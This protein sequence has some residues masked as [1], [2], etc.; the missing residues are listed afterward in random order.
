M[1][2]G[3]QVLL[4]LLE[5]AVKALGPA[6]DLAVVESH[7]RHKKDAPSGTAKALVAA[8]DQARSR[9]AAPIPVH[10]LRGGDVVGDHTVHFLGPG[11]RLEL[12]HRATSRQTFAEGALRAAR[13]LVGRPP[14][15]YTMQQVLGIGAHHD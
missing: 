13:W 1:S 14:G 2:V 5:P 12:V 7:H 10:A 6:Y 4:A 3:V 9:E 15:R 8:L 11:D